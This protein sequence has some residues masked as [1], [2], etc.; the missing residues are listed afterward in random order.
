MAGYR[1]FMKQRNQITKDAW[2]KLEEDRKKEIEERKTEFKCPICGHFPLIRPKPMSDGISVA[3]GH[4]IS[5]GVNNGLDFSGGLG[6]VQIDDN[7][8]H[9]H[10]YLC[11]NCGAKF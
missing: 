1:D 9:E 8:W 7:R 2:S 10:K 3:S 6:I 5:Y 11:E 4:G